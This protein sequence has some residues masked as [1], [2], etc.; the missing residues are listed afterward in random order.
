M[1]ES[2]DVNVVRFVDVLS[3]IRSQKF[4]YASSSSVYGNTACKEADEAWDRFQPSDY[5]DLTKKVID[6]YAELSDVRFYGLRMGTVA[7]PSPNLRVDTMINKM[8]HSA[9]TTGKI[10]I[11][12]P[13]IYRPILGINDLCRAVSKLVDQDCEHGFYNLAS[14]N[15]S[16]SEISSAVASEIDG[17]EV[18]HAGDTPTYDF[19]VSTQKAQNVLGLKFE[20]TIHSIVADLNRDYDNCAKGVRV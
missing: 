3:K 15:A 2:F 1:V 8:Y 7:G 18:I 9:R 12:N 20:D 6:L 14:F 11:Y 10:S 19:S 16:V 4:I 17:V 13:H 5:Y